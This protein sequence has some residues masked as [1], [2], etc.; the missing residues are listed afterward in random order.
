MLSSPYWEVQDVVAAWMVHHL[1][2]QSV[3]WNVI[4]SWIEPDSSPAWGVMKVYKMLADTSGDHTGLT[5]II[6][7]HLTAFDP[8]LRGN[9]VN[10]L[11]QIM[12]NTPTAELK[13]FFYRMEGVY[14]KSFVRR[15]HLGDS[16][17]D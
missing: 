14:R 4:L 5:T 11:Y 15:R 7:A 17:G 3:V 13:A 12:L 9:A 1:S 8:Q 2:S 6:H 10:I 16:R